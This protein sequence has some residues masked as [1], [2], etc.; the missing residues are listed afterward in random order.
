MGM[1]FVMLVLLVAAEVYYA[2]VNASPGSDNVRSLTV[3]LSI[4]LATWMVLIGILCSMAKKPAES[5]P[6]TNPM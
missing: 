5:V 6:A 1:H 4:E 2:I 3:S